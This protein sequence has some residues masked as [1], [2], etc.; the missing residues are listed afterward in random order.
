[1]AFFGFAQEFGAFGTAGALSAYKVGLGHQEGQFLEV[2]FDVFARPVAQRLG[3]EALQHIWVG[4]AS[5]SVWFFVEG[6][7]VIGDGIWC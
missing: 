4:R 7:W 1:V 6:C 2:F 3:H 5:D